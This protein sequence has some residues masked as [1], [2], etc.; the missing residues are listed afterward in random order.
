MEIFIKTVAGQSITLEVEL[1]DSIQSVKEKIQDHTGTPPDHQRLIF[2]GRQ[3]QDD[4]TLA[5]Y[6]IEKESTIEIILM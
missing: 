1:S 4:K 6:G 5:D 3:L 2:L